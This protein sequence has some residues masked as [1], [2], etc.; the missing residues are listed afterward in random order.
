VLF[1]DFAVN[2]SVCIPVDSFAMETKAVKRYVTVGT[3]KAANKRVQ[4][5]A[6][7]AVAQL[8]AGAYLSSG[9]RLTLPTRTDLEAAGRKVMASC[10]YKKAA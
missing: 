8:S 7:S 4:S 9:K 5:L 1:Y 3:V 6:G 10:M 2:K